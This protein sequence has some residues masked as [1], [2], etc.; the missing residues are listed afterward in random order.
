MFMKVIHFTNC[1]K[2]RVVNGVVIA[3]DRYVDGLRKLGVEALIVGPDY[4]VENG[5]LRAKTGLL[6]R[7]IQNFILKGYSFNAVF[8]DD[9]LENII[10][11]DVFHIQ[12]PPFGIYGKGTICRKGFNL[13]KKEGKRIVLHHH[14][15][16]DIYSKLYIPKAEFFKI[17]EFF[18]KKD[19][20]YCNESDCVIAP[21]ES[22]K[23]LLL[24]WGVESRVEVVPTDVDYDRFSKGDRK[25][26]RDKYGI[27]ED[28]LVFLFVGRLS[29]E[30]NVSELAEALKGLN[31]RKI[32][33]GDGPNRGDLEG[34]IDGIFPG[35]INYNELQD[36]YAAA[37]IFGSMS[38]SESQSLTIYEAHAAGLPILALESPGF[39]ENVRNGIDGYL[40]NNKDEF[41]VGLL[42]LINNRALLKSLGRGAR[43]TTAK[44]IEDSGSADRL[45]NI[46]REL[47][48]Y[49]S[50]VK[51]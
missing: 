21:S 42:E 35:M 41:K 33:V 29:E 10:D 44:R 27:K 11:A 4:N 6:S 13:G 38:T 9:I 2:P 1:F 8:S 45:L 36:Y 22:I 50:F 18:K 26:I 37:D 49:E 30:K 34:K 14:T 46:Y 7:S 23:D 15:R 20:Q 48:K 31:I 16:Y 3:T 28:E 5:S 12:H 47:T 40:F 43:E 25:K 32:F 39:K 19:V 17:D 51:V 24:N